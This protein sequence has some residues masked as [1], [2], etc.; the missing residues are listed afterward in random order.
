MIYQIAPV[1]L[2]GAIGAVLRYILGHI[3]KNHPLPWATFIINIAGSFLI[4]IILALYQKH[5]YS[6]G[7]RLFWAVGICG[8]FTTFSAF[9]QESLHL[10]QSGR[11]GTALLY[12]SLSILLGIAATALGYKFVNH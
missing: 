8:G 5:S 12:I 10:L 2:G 1:A 4:G 6:E 3:I 11:A 7:M 9:S